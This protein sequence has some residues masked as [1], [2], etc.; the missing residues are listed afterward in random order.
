MNKQDIIE[1]F[2]ES[3]IDDIDSS[4]KAKP[5]D[6]IFRIRESL[7]NLEIVLKLNKEQLKSYCLDEF[8]HE[9]ED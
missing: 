5:N 8:G 6:L 9:L 1:S 3:I 4:D 7:Y 2:F